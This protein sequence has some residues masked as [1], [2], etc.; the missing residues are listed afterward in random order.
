MF[1]TDKPINEINEDRLGRS[2]FATQLASAIM[3]F[4]TY[5][6]YTVSL[7]GKWGCGKTSILNMTIKELERLCELNNSKSIK[8]VK[9]NPWNFTNTNQLISQFFIT[10][11]SSLNINN[12][13]KTFRSVG[14]AIER[15][16]SALEI[17]EYI[18]GVGLNIKLISML[19]KK[20][21]ESL[22]EKSEVKLNDVTYRKSQVELALKRI[23]TRII[24]IIDDIDRLSNEQI[25]L[26]FQ[27]VNAVAD[28]PNITYL[29]S[30][31]RDIV[32]RALSNIQQCNG[33]EYL[34]K[35]IQVPFDVPHLNINKLHKILFEKLDDIVVIQS[36]TE[37]DVKR[38]SKVF[39]FCISPFISTLRDIKR[40]Y[41]VLS[42][43]YSTVSEEVDFIDMAGICAL[44]VFA[45]PIYE[46]IRD[47]R[48][49]LVGGYN[50]GGISQNDIGKNEKDMLKI[51]E[52]IYPSNPRIMLNAVG[53]LFP[54]FANRVSFSPDF[55]TVS[56]I[57][58]AM[59]I[60]SDTK[61][62]LYFYLSLDNIKLSRREIDNSLFVM[63]GTELCLYMNMLKE[64]K[65]FDLYLKE[66]KHNLSRIP[67]NRIELLLTNII[68]QSGQII[69][70]REKILTLGSSEISVYIISDIL[71]RL[72]DENQRYNFIANMLLN[73]DYLAFQFLLHLVHIIELTHGRIAETEYRQNPKLVNLE[74]LIRL[75]IIFL[76]RIRGFCNI[77]NIFEWD[78]LRRVCMLWEFIEKDEYS[79]F[80]KSEISNKINAIRFLSLFVGVWTS[81]GKE[82]EYE[83]NNYDYKDYICDEKLDALVR[84]IRY[85][86]EFW[87]LDMKIINKFVVFELAMES[88]NIKNMIKVDEVNKRVEL[89]KQ[90]FFA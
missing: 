64:S 20:F 58:Q 68:F 45:S 7:Q 81:N 65:L 61:F 83:I 82:H 5:E 23:N 6:N 86:E 39:N 29:L 67:E 75:E 62:D 76:D 51:F 28:F 87:E 41:N 3:K 1:S 38:W 12:K 36:E 88:D 79:K 60:A 15:Y 85:S 77:M 49:S 73:S 2:T 43:T 8:V 55:T 90:N 19:F 54:V 25:Q 40:F 10:L 57:H 66:V 84:E 11:T 53:S 37:F 70:N 24:V 42:F 35:I 44:R 47:N 22:K 27:L 48:Y 33:E 59:R 17:S 16:S 32:A 69:E 4:D 18:P 78:N 50:G 80:I 72:N 52:N 13:D 34:E 71:F 63:S 30:F 74:N 26:I 89:W 14:T 56:E 31:D 21:G 46:W 9:F